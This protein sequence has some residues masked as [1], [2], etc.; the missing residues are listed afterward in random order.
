[1]SWLTWTYPATATAA[2]LVAA[3]LLRAP[4]A[5]DDEVTDPY[6]AAYLR[7]GRRGAV[8]VALVALHLRGTVDAGP[9]GTARISGP[10]RDL[11]QPL[12]RAVYEALYRPSGVNTVA[13]SRPVRRPLDALRGRLAGAGLIRGDRRWR[14]A[15]VLLC[16]AVLT[17]VWELASGPLPPWNSP[18]RTA[19]SAVP[20]AAAVA[21][22]AVPRRTGAGRRVLQRARER[23]PRPRTRRASPES[24]LL[25][26]ALHGE[27]ALRLAVPHFTRE[28]GLLARRDGTESLYGVNHWH[29][30]GG[31]SGTSACGSG[32]V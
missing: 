4:R 14:A 10:A 16:A 20:V 3:A 6:E 27:P 29:S 21:L 17:V 15:R 8:V 26:V 28:A 1:M 24:V 2:L 32:G 13:A 22:W 5:A 11:S 31:G 23:F 25:A 30:G 7:D 18:L 12:Q 19:V 9:R